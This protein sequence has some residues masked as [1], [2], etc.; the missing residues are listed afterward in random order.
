[1]I[2]RKNTIFI[3]RSIPFAIAAAFAILVN[4]CGN[5]DYTNLD[6]K[7]MFHNQSPSADVRFSESIAYNQQN[8][9]DM[10]YIHA[11]QNDYRVYICT[12]SHVD[13]TTHNMERFVD[14]YKK[15]TLCPFA[16]HLGDL[17][18]AQH[19]Y[20]RFDSCT[21]R[22]P[23]GGVDKPLYK[24][25]GNHDLYFGQWSEFRKY[26]HTS[27][28]ALTVNTPDF[29]DLFICIDSGSGVLGPKQLK[30]L[31]TILAE[32]EGKYRHLILFT[33]THVFKQDNSQGHTDNYNM[34]ETYELLGLMNKYGVEMVLMGHDHSREVSRYGRTNYIIVD[35]IQDP[36]ERPAYMILSMNELQYEFIELPIKPGGYKY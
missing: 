22:V 7:G 28:Y 3:H 13:S 35:S 26:Y 14:D 32:S 18:N 17:I 24:T 23:E 16:I 27:T 11:P 19:H 30:W 5:P 6:I 31:R 4:S 20:A 21:H 2:M 36:Q 33:H 9:G 12:D 15:D 34:E 1:M 25:A 8:G 29:K 10:L